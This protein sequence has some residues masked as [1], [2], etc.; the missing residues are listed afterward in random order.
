MARRKKSV[1]PIGIHM[2]LESAHMVQLE[3]AEMGL[4][5]VSKARF[6][7]PPVP[8]TEAEPSNGLPSPQRRQL[9]EARLDD[10]RQS[11]RHTLASDGFRGKEAVISLPEDYVVIQHLRMAPMQPEELQSA[12]PW[13]LQGKLSFDPRAAVVRH[14]VVGAVSENNETKQD[15]I[16]LA[17]VRATVEKHVLAMEKLGLEVIGVGVEPCAMGYAYAYGS[18]HGP[19]TQE[20]PESLMLVLLGASTTHVSI[21]RG[22]ETQFVKDV[23]LGT[24][25]L[26]R[27]MAR[28][29][30][31][32][33]EEASGMRARWRDAAPENRPHATEEA[34]KAYTAIRWDL[35]P[36][37]DELESCMRYHSSLGRGAHVSRVVFLGPEARDRALV[38]VLGAS[39]RVP[40]E[41]GHPLAAVLEDDGEAE[42]EPELSVA[43]GLS[44]F[45]AA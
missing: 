45:T 11:V 39:L 27:A 23:D 2:G 19:Q 12:L 30:S 6:Q 21:V 26:A 29:L 15:V 9:I 16:V 44:L 20:G 40:C 14:I 25:H 31:V 33:S 5:L 4:R 32:S 28:E 34:V 35:G 3:Q 36:L 41:V 7:F 43:A 42:A 24:T 18:T 10:A 8:D 38:K 13:E 22:M 1:L 37:V 17:A